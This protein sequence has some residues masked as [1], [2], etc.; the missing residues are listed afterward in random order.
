MEEL[1]GDYVQDSDLNDFMGRVKKTN[2]QMLK[3]YN[4]AETMVQKKFLKQNA[5]HI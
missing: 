5:L 3:I 1:D 2:A 4:S